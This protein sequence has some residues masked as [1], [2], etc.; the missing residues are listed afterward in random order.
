MTGFNFDCQ[1]DASHYRSN[2]HLSSVL[3]KAVIVIIVTTLAVTSGMTRTVDRDDGCTFA[4]K[5]GEGQGGYG[6]R[7]LSVMEMAAGRD[8]WT[9]MTDRS[10]GV[11]VWWC[12][13][14]RSK[15]GRY[16]SSLALQCP[17]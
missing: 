1:S 6:V 13:M 10:G 12:L 8:S 15:E 16:W 4:G 11:V 5:V 17:V 9:A 7:R 2:C 3:A 14:V